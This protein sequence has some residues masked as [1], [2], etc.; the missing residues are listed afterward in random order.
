MFTIKPGDL[1]RSD[2]NASTQAVRQ[3][4]EEILEVYIPNRLPDEY[5]NDPV[6]VCIVI[7][8]AMSETVREMFTGFCRMHRNARVEFSE[9]NGERLAGMLMS[10]N[11]GE[12]IIVRALRSPLQKSIAMV[13]FPDISEQ[14]F[15]E[16]ASLIKN[17]A[18]DDA[19]LIRAALQINVCAWMIYAWC[20]QAGNMESALRASEVS[21]I[22]LWSLACKAEGGPVKAKMRQ[23]FSRSV[24]M[25]LQVF[26][27]F[28]EDRIRPVMSSPDW[29]ARAVG[30]RSPVDGSLIG[31]RLLG[32]CAI[33][34]LWRRWLEDEGRSVAGFRNAASYLADAV[35]IWERNPVLVLPIADFQSGS[36][37]SVMLLSAACRNEDSRLAA[38][39]GEMI[40]RLNFALVTRTRYPTVFTSYSDLAMHP[41]GKD[42]RYFER[43]GGG[44]TLVPLVA[45]FCR[46]KGLAA[47]LGMLSEIIGK[48]WPKVSLQLWMADTSSEDGLLQELDNHGKAVLIEY[49]TGL[50]AVQRQLAAALRTNEDYSKLSM[51]SGSVS[52]LLA[53]CCTRIGLPLPAQLI[54]DV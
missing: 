9:W 27:T 11:H 43:A 22:T 4:L 25:H 35:D 18:D 40:A 24:E 28:F 16:L 37:G 3:S 19:G 23:S 50:T 10:G 5:R 31:Y 20:R 17:A 39:V 7:G 21:L 36:V 46:A 30:S 2:W 49:G 44:S 13:D 42:D 34:G 1:T 47:E 12:S 29:L 14:H 51:I 15:K 54:A 41:K 45:L 8:G 53:L 33:A 38:I 26:E 48:H 32:R 6:V 52:P